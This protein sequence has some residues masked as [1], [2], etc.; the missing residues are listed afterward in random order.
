MPVHAAAGEYLVKALTDLGWM[1][2]DRR[3]ELLR[4]GAAT[5]GRWCGWAVVRFGFVAGLG[6]VA[7]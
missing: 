6:A 4:L 7:G 5:V 3:P 1:P 2:T